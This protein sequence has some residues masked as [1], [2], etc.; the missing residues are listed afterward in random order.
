MSLPGP[1]APDGSPVELYA[2]APPSGE[3]EIVHAAI[4]TDA[5]ILE[6]GCGAGR[7]THRLVELGHPVVGVDQS[8]EMLANVRGAETVLAD[9]EVLDLGRTFPVVLL[10]SQLLNTPDQQQRSAFLA[11]CRRHVQSDGVVVIQRAS[12]ALAT[13]PDENA[14]VVIEVH[15]FRRWLHNP[16]LEGRIL[17]GE[18]HHQFGDREWVESFTTRILDDDEIE[19][20]LVAVALRLDRWLD[21]KRIWFAATSL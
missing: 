6:L 20:E 7:M 21:P 1:R 10:A 8:P 11:T 16:R 12:R 13:S 2:L 14:D 15:G 18:M 19:S 17:Y 5:E 9:I 3:P 4:P